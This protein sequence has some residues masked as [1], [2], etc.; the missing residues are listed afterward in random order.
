MFLAIA[1]PA[2]ATVEFGLLVPIGL[3]GVGIIIVLVIFGIVHAN[4]EAKGE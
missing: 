4:E 2:W 3:L 1:T